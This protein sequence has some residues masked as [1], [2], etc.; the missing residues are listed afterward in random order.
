MGEISKT[1]KNQRDNKGGVNLKELKERIR[2]TTKVGE[3]SKK[4]KNQRDNKGGGN[5]KEMKESEGQQRWGKSQRNERIRGTPKEIP[6]KKVVVWAFDAKWVLYRKDS[7]RNGGTAY[8]GEGGLGE[9]GQCEGWYRS[10]GTV[11]GGSV[12]PCYMEAYVIVHRSH[13]KVGLR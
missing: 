2:G 1:W 10:E 11:G 7:D 13:I 4:W 3:I 8:T 5:L 6:G 12:W 9:G